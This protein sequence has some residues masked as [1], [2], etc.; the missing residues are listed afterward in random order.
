MRKLHG[1][2]TRH[3]FLE[4]KPRKIMKDKGICMGCKYENCFFRTK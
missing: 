1:V 2:K 4:E 3:L